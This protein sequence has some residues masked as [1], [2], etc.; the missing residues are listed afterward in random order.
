MKTKKLA[1]HPE[2]FDQQIGVCGPSPISEKDAKRYWKAQRY[3]MNSGISKALDQIP[4]QKNVA[5]IGAGACYDFDPQKIICDAQVRHLDLID[6]DSSSSEFALNHAMTEIRQR[7]DTCLAGEVQLED[8]VGVIEM[9]ATLILADFFKKLASL[10][11]SHS[12]QLRLSKSSHIPELIEPIAVLLEEAIT[13]AQLPETLKGKYNLVVSDCILSQMLVAIEQRIA[14]YLEPIIRHDKLGSD[15][16][17]HIKTRIPEIIIPHHIQ[18]MQEMMTEGG[19]VFLAS[20]QITL[21]HNTYQ[22][23]QPRVTL[24]GGDLEAIITKYC[25]GFEVQSRRDWKWNRMPKELY[26]HHHYPYET[27][28]VTGVILRELGE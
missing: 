17:M 28:L 14:L 11:K 19:R 20:D 1:T 25:P 24:E 12:H 9:E 7:T 5:V 18:T 15:L 3:Q 16:W 13:E 8:R 27:E 21:L 4:G 23:S 2:N 10:K 22:K 6:L 26:G